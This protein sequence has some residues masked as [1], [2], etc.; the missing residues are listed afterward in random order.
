M[1]K[2]AGEVMNPTTEQRRLKDFGKELD[3]YQTGLLS[4]S[5][6][7]DRYTKGNHLTYAFRDQRPSVRKALSTMEHLV[8]GA[9]EHMRAIRETYESMLLSPQ[10]LKL[11]KEEYAAYT[12][13]K[14]KTKQEGDKNVQT[15]KEKT[16]GPHGVDDSN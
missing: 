1:P 3:R 12:A 8:S 16:K 6:W 13:A 15:K 10:E 5:A 14:K 4:L 2:K 7:L 11:K 9:H